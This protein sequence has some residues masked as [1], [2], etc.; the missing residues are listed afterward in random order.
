MKFQFKLLAGKH[1]EGRVH[2]V[3]GDVVE[4][5][6]RLDLMFKNKFEILNPPKETAQKVK[7]SAGGGKDPDP[8]A[9][10]APASNGV[11]GSVTLKAKHMGKGR[12]DVLKVVNG[13]VTDETVN[14][15]FLSK[16]D[17]EAMVAAGYQQE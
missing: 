1:F 10:T 5:D 6:S 11:E 7:G 3:A 17:A 16:S 4:S 13:K 12:F 9:V 2:A 8:K 15:D 14:D